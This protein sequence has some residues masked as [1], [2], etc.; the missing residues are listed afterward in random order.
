MALPDDFDADLAE[1]IDDLPVSITWN[2]ETV[3][4]MRS[5]IERHDEMGSIAVRMEER[6][7][8]AQFRVAAW[9]S[10]Y[11]TTGDKITMESITYRVTAHRLSRD[12][13]AVEVTLEREGA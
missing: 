3:N 13:I 11:P 6:F 10:T 4:A 12:G 2:G 7:V 5:P 1:I 8:T 9:T